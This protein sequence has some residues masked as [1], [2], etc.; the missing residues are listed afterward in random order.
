[1]LARS[2]A[3]GRR[4][5]SRQSTVCY[6]GRYY[7]TAQP[8]PPLELPSTRAAPNEFINTNDLFNNKKVLLVG[9]VGAFTGVCQRQ[10]PGFASKAKDFKAKGIDQIAVVSVNDLPTMKAF[11]DSLGV[12]PEEV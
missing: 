12:D 5:V 7:A 8:N 1:M 4:T 9:I 3:I 2:F 6:A 11:S 10:I